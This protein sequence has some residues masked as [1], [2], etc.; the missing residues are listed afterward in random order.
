MQR[1]PHSPTSAVALAVIAKA[2]VPG[3]VKTRLCPPFTGTEAAE[4]AAASLHDTLAA[5]AATPA[6]RRVLVL[7][8]DP[9]DWVPS[10]FAVIAQR[11]AG[12]GA[13]LAHAFADCAARGAGP[14]VLVGMDT[15]QLTPALL[16]AAGEL[17]TSGSAD[18]RA[19]LGPAADGGYWLIGLSAADPGVFAGVPMSAADTG[20]RQVAQLVRRGFTVRPV[21]EL[22]DVDTAADAAAVAAAAPHTAFA[23][24]H[25]RLTRTAALS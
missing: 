9:G 4:L 20:R 12:L 6:P 24:A 17:V 14:V 5:V 25:A 2:P 21:A 1:N 11:G 16:A 3:R 18:R 15:P 8:G 13:R 19:V 22:R 23:R 7:D 10:G